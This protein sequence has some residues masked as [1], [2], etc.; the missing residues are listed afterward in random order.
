MD[1]GPR[2]RDRHSAFVPVGRHCGAALVALVGL[3]IGACTTLSGPA[4]APDAAAA[5]EPIP[6]PVVARLVVP[7]RPPPDAKP[8]PPPAPPPTP[9][10]APPAPVVLLVSS[11]LPAYVD[12]AARLEALLGAERVKGYVLADSSNRANLIADIDGSNPRVT[13]AI[14]LDAALFAAQELA[15][16]FVFCQVLNY[17]DH[18][19]LQRAAAGVSALPSISQQ[20][21]YW[22]NVDPGLQ[23]VGAIVG[24]GHED[25]ILEA[26]QAAAAQKLN[27]KH[28]TSQSDQETIYLF[29]RLAA[30]IDGFWLIPDNRILSLHAIREIL[31]YASEKRVRV[32][33]SSPGLL[34]YGALMSLSLSPTQIA[35]AV[36]NVIES[37]PPR[38]AQN[39]E[40][41]APTRFDVEINP[42]VAERFGIEFD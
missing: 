8:A 39:P 10:P 18:A 4:P 6:I 13:V 34:K 33:V 28:R 31:T 38:N 32:V 22:R 24:P 19:D 16:P 3:H 25:L 14:G 2:F 1:A 37:L 20:F 42:S 9:A 21:R 27:F 35:D 15:S 30:Q 5:I 23:R 12:V 36:Y 41:H 7:Q 11:E 29:K 17:A 26:E 40:V